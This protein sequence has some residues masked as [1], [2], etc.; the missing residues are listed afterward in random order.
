MRLQLPN[1]PMIVIGDGCRQTADV[2]ALTR[3]M[4]F[5]RGVAD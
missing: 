3:Y 4:V 5:S 2:V 1:L